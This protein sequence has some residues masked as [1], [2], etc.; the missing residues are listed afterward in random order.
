[1]CPQEHFAYY[2]RPFQHVLCY[3]KDWATLPHFIYRYCYLS[4]TNYLAIRLPVTDNFSACRN[5]LGENHLSFPS[6]PRCVRHSYL[7][8]GLR[9]I[10]LLVGHQ[11]PD[12]MWTRKSPSL[13]F[14][15][16]WGCEAFVKRLMSDKLA[17]FQTLDWK[18]VNTT[19]LFVEFLP[20]VGEYITFF[21]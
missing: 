14:L 6:A 2:K 4:I 11:T 18:I 10:P 9:L 5:Y 20:W 7:S 15:K 19:L 12:E 1:M 8:K 3:K 21:F 17:F 16:I 13:S